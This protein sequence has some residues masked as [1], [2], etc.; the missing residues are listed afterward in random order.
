M[1]RHDRRMKKAKN[2]VQLLEIWG[3]YGKRGLIQMHRGGGLFDTV[4]FFRECVFRTV[5]KDCS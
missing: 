1:N 4:A 2:M 3:A 5:T